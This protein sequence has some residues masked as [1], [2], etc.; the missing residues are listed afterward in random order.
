[1]S[2]QNDKLGLRGV[3]AV[4][5]ELVPG[6]VAHAGVEVS[7]VEGIED[8][9]LEET[10]VVRVGAVDEGH[11]AVFARYGVVEDVVPEQVRGLPGLNLL[12]HDQIGVDLIHDQAE[13]VD[14]R[15]VVIGEIERVVGADL[16]RGGGLG[17]DGKHN[18]C[19]K[20]KEPPGGMFR[21]QRGSS[22]ATPTTGGS[23]HSQ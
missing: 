7:V 12:E 4:G 1:M 21:T 18:G 16:D 15:G 13:G 6:G 10:R 2:G 20:K 14:A 9:R 23:Q 3:V 22:S 8:V 5:P 19:H 17:R 11:P